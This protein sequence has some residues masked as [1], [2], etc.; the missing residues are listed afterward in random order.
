M[1]QRNTETGT[2]LSRLRAIRHLHD[3]TELFLGN[4]LFPDVGP[5]STYVR[6]RPPV[7]VLDGDSVSREVRAFGQC[8]YGGFKRV[9]DAKR[10]EKRKEPNIKHDLRLSR[11]PTVSRVCRNTR[12]P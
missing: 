8:E 7:G 2:C 9:N 10:W 6:V 12:K 5:D 3:P 11:A 1:L 4:M